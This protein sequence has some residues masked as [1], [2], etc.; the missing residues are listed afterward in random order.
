MGEIL[1]TKKNISVIIPAFNEEKTIGQVV[2]TALNHPLV[3]EVIV[4]DDGSFDNTVTEAK[5]AGS[6]VIVHKKNMGKAAAMKTGVENASHS[7]IFF[8]DADIKGLTHDMMNIAIT[9]VQNNISDMFV[10]IV[11]HSSIISEKWMGLLPLIGGVRVIRRNIWNAI[12]EQ[13]KNRYEIE[14]A[15]NFFARKEN[16][17]IDYKVIKGLTQVIKEKKRGLAWGLYQRFFMMRDLVW[18]II[19]LYLIYN[20]YFFIKS[21]ISFRKI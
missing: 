15:M 16:A 11:D 18:V 3:D 12:P 10:L 7:I 21:A 20:T 1:Y 17:R 19:K 6:Q 2:H 4:I 13:F 5:K 14:L 8:I 9:S